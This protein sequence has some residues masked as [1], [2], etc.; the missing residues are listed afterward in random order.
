MRCDVS[1][2]FY[3]WAGDWS[4][5][6]VSRNLMILSAGA[7]PY[8]SSHCTIFFSAAAAAC[9]ITVMKLLLSVEITKHRVHVFNNDVI[10]LFT[11]KHC[12]FRAIS[13]STS[14]TNISTDR[15]YS[16]SK[17]TH[18][19]L[20][21]HISVLSSSWSQWLYLFV[22]GVS[23]QNDEYLSLYTLRYA[24]FISGAIKSWQI[25][26]LAYQ[27][28]I[29]IKVTRKGGKCDALQLESAWRPSSRTR[30]SKTHFNMGQLSYWWFGKFSL[31]GI[32]R[33]SVSI[34]SV[35]GPIWT[36]NP[37][38]LLFLSFTEKFWYRH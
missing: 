8:S 11:W 16:M 28:D 6:R 29:E 9:S 32:C 15:F 5:C 13:Y 2:E 10:V 27:H 7:I 24:N 17:S 33:Q 12:C 26:S 4:V 22:Y 34:V 20:S 30:H 14:P 38:K 19:P 21:T 31:K 23:Q 36:V 1:D 35:R 37:Q 25:P 18:Y 3:F